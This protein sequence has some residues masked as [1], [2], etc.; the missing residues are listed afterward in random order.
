MDPGDAADPKSKGRAVNG[1]ECVFAATH[2]PK[3]GPLNLVLKEAQDD[4]P[5]NRF[6]RC[7]TSR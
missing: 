7:G 6:K 4:G 1:S 3:Y 2:N 5:R